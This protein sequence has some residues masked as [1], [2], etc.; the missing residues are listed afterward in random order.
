MH[1]KFLVDAGRGIMRKLVFM[2]RIM[3]VDEIMVLGGIIVVI[4]ASV[5]VLVGIAIDLSMDILLYNMI[6]GSRRCVV[7]EFPM[8]C[9]GVGVLDGHLCLDCMDAPR[10]LLDFISKI[11]VSLDKLSHLRDAQGDCDCGCGCG[12]VGQKID[13]PTTLM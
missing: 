7:V 10:E 11:V 3:F 1:G 13:R 6:F 9:S 5:T 12:H 2:S 4:M 8:K